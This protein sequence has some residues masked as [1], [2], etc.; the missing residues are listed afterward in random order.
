MRF[1]KYICISPPE[2]TEAHIF[3]ANV[4]GFKGEKYFKNGLFC[5][6]GIHRFPADSKI[7]VNESGISCN[8][9]K[10]KFKFIFDSIKHRYKTWKI[11]KNLKGSLE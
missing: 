11:M 2:N 6:Y 3:R 4:L 10:L 5:D 7:Y 1:N 8:K 9:H